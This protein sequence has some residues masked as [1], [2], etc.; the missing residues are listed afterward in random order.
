MLRNVFGP[1]DWL[2][3]QVLE[4]VER[5]QSSQPDELLQARFEEAHGEK[6]SLRSWLFTQAFPKT[7][8]TP[9]M[10]DGRSLV[11]VAQSSFIPPKIHRDCFP[12][13]IS[14]QAAWLARMAHGAR[15]R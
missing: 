13:T 3:N 9:K 14:V 6:A 2:L 5:G 4:R 15:P 11:Q 12:A 10:S 8:E 1:Q 7:G